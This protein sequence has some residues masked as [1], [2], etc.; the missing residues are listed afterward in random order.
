M[1]VRLFIFVI[2]TLP[3]WC[4]AQ[5][6]SKQK[7]IEFAD[8]LSQKKILTEKGK[9]SL[10]DNIKRNA[11]TS[12]YNNTYD[13]S[14]TDAALL[15]YCHVVFFYEMLYRSGYVESE[16]VTKKKLRQQRRARK[17][18]GDDY[19]AYDAWLQKQI[20]LDSIRMEKLFLKRHHIEDAIPAEDSTVGFWSAVPLM[21]YTHDLKNVVETSRS[22]MGKTRTRTTKDI[23][24]IGLIDQKIFDDI[25]AG[26]KDS[27]IA[28]EVDVFNVAAMRSEY[29]Q[30][31]PTAKTDQL[32][33][34]DS[35]VACDVLLPVHRDLLVNTYQ[36]FE[37]KGDF[38]ILKYCNNSILLD[39]KGYSDPFTFYPHVYS[40]LRNIVPGFDFDTLKVRLDSIP[41]FEAMQC[42]ILL[43]FQTG[44]EV[45]ERRIGYEWPM[46]GDSLN[47]PDAY[48]LSNADFHELLNDWLADHGSPFRLYKAVQ[49]YDNW[50]NF[51]IALILLTE[52]QRMISPGF[53]FLSEE[54]HHAGLDKKYVNKL[55]NELDSI[56]LFSH[57]TAE[58]I[59]SGRLELSRQ[60]IY[61]AGD[62][63]TYF[64]K[65]VHNFYWDTTIPEGS[66]KANCSA[67]GRISRDGFKPQNVWDDFNKKRKARRGKV[68]F[69]FE[70]NGKKYSK[71]LRGTTDWPA[72]EFIALIKKAMQENPG[73]GNFYSLYG[74]DSGSF[75]YL[76]D[77]QF[78][79][80]KKHLSQVRVD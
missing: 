6:I 13:T 10:I 60:P 36:P 49:Q 7:A 51:T 53:Q 24:D 17:R 72:L 8:Q 80:F 2:I 15:Q 76:T 42:D 3:P 56:G 25:I 30:S 78:E 18:F 39:T 27:T 22:V 14:V 46:D 12:L 38:E 47:T 61:F 26:I 29:Y 45:H 73:N 44:E 48:S 59:D 4:Q 50:T 68:T 5:V 52:E 58:Q 37:L 57:L 19:Q 33:F 55:I 21:R 35:L 1:P 16:R 43:S 28:T 69:H 64:P 20:T 67:L 62:I 11:F 65:V 9:S 79:Y 70:Y 34:L 31:Y 75:I 40:Q 23:L 77:E 54:N 71:T 74:P 66:F 32:A 63:L 41:V